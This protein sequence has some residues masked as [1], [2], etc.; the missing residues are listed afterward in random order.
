M[1]PLAVLLAALFLGSAAGQ[2]PKGKPKF[3]NRLAKET[4]PYLLMH[5]HNPT[6]WYAWVRI[7]NM[8]LFLQ[9]TEECRFYKCWQRSDMM[10]GAK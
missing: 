7:H 4:S 10:P 3:T 6:D 9:R 5:A 2:P 1:R 8:R